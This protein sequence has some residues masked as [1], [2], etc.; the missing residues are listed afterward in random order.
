MADP[1]ADDDDAFAPRVFDNALPPE[2]F[3]ALVSATGLLPNRTFSFWTGLR[4]TEP[5][6]VAEVVEHLLPLVALPL[7]DPATAGVEWWVRRAPAYHFQPWHVD[8]DDA[9]FMRDGVVRCPA[10]SSIL[11]LGDAGGPTM[12]SSQICGPGGNSL[13]PRRLERAWTVAPR[14][15]RF[16]VFRGDAAHAVMPS[17]EP[18]HGIRTTFPVNFWPSPTVRTERNS[19]DVADHPELVRRMSTRVEAKTRAPRPART[20]IRAWQA[21]E[22]PRVVEQRW[23]AW[24]SH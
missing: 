8:K 2:L 3:A 17:R 1:A 20:P 4:D 15:N 7:L 6:L 23:P 22:L 13:V 5:A 12:V 9:L 19:V 10:A 11:Y 24:V 21:A 16:V 14:A 18:G